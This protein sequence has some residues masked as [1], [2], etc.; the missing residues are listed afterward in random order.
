MSEATLTPK[1]P[2][3]S[4]EEAFMAIIALQ[5]GTRDFGYHLALGGGVLN[6]G[7]SNKDLDLYFLPLNGLPQDTDGLVTWLEEHFGYAEPIGLSNTEYNPDTPSVE[8]IK[9][10]RRL[11]FL[12]DDRRIDAFVIEGPQLDQLNSARAIDTEEDT[13]G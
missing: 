6:N 9:Y 12:F 3:W 2:M 5:G 7:F 1:E 13:L 8:P 11:K 4:F 10:T